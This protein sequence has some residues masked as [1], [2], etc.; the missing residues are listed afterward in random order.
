MMKEIDPVELGI[1]SAAPVEECYDRFVGSIGCWW[2]IAY[3]WGETDFATATI[4][5][6]AGGRWYETLRDGSE[7]DWG[8]VRV[9]EP[10]ARLVLSFNAGPDRSPEPAERQSEVEVRFVPRGDR[11]RVE[12][13]HRDLARH[14]AKADQLREAMA[15]PQGWPLILASF[16]REMRYLA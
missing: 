14:G 4:E 11:T 12:L 15:S 5:R 10:G 9:V 2:P 13:E 3:T 8:E 16:A 6:R 7:R 1:E